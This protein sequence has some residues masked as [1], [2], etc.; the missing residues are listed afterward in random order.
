MNSIRSFDLFDTLV[1]RDALDPKE[2]FARVEKEVCAGNPEVAGFARLRIEA[3]RSSRDPVSRETDL[4]TIYRRL[5]EI[6]GW[7]FQL[8]ET[9][10]EAELRSEI[11]SMHGVAEAIHEVREAKGSG[12]RLLL[13]TDMYLPRAAIEALLEKVGLEGAFDEVH[14]SGECGHSKHTGQLYHHIRKCLAEESEWSHEGDNMFSDVRQ[15]K[16]AGLRAQWR[17]GALPNERERSLQLENEDGRVAG[18]ARISRLGGMGQSTNFR[19]VGANISGPV[20]YPYVRWVLET[21]KAQGVETLYFLSRDGQLLCRIAEAVRGRDATFPDCRYLYGSRQAWLGALRNGELAEMVARSSQERHAVAH[22]YLVQEGLVGKRRIGVVDIGWKGS[23]QGMLENILA[24]GGNKSVTVLGFNYGLER[25][26]H[27]ERQFAFCFGPSALPHR[28]SLYPSVIEM[29]TPADHGQVTGY[30]R[31]PGGKVEPV[32]APYSVAPADAIR[33]LHEGA[34]AFVN[35]CLEAGIDRV[36]SRETLSSFLRAPKE[37]E[38]SVFREF[39]FSIFPTAET[40]HRDFLLPR[41]SIRRLLL[42]TLSP[43]RHTATWPWPEATWR[44]HFPRVPST[45]LRLLETK[46]YLGRLGFQLLKDRRPSLNPSMK[47]RR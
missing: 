2:I 42:L 41:A 30:R 22:D 43:F 10:C 37:N 4:A 32:C 23:M 11:E 26:M 28:L 31:T 6:T 12:S 1:V 8:L 27:P 44:M 39:A 36:C 16:K 14:I 40:P 24:K 20:F 46:R 47:P 3:E 25:V 7:S 19:A 35:L 33:S 13:L 15:A 21:A 17:G 9:L 34:M 5:G 38:I 45:L 29:L 18:F